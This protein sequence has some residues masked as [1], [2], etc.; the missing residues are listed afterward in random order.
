MNTVVLALDVGEVRIGIAEATTFVRIAHP[1]KT[2]SRANVVKELNAIIDAYK[3]ELFVVGL[4]RNAQG[5]K[6]AQT[7]YV[8]DFVEEFMSGKTVVYQD[9]SLTSVQAERELAARKKPYQKEDIDA[10]AAAYILQDYLDGL[11]L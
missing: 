10:L 5:E 6:T 9:E 3:P 1:L 4:P 11:A 7:Q 2:I 8:Y